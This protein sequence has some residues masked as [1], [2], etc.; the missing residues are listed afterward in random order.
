MKKIARHW[1]LLFKVCISLSDGLA[2]SRKMLIQSTSMYHPC[3]CV[4]ATGL[5]GVSLLNSN[6]EDGR[7]L[8]LTQDLALEFELRLPPTFSSRVP[9]SS[10]CE[11]VPGSGEFR[12]S[13]IF[14]TLPNTRTPGCLHSLSS[15]FAGSSFPY[16]TRVVP[17]NNL[18]FI[19]ADPSAIYLV[20]GTCTSYTGESLTTSSLINITTTGKCGAH[21]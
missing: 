10:L 4:L 14:T 5:R 17:T 19:F 2:V 13:K 6:P 12:R 1:Y 15:N 16:I 9:S 7:P 8:L 18:S 11:Q 3:V 20:Y 21:L